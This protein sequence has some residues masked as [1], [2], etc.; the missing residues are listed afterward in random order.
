MARNLSLPVKRFVPSP[1]RPIFVFWVNPV[2]S[3][4]HFKRVLKMRQSL[5]QRCLVVIMSLLSEP[6]LLFRTRLYYCGRTL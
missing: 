2:R 3:K 5:N 1:D 4:R 6:D